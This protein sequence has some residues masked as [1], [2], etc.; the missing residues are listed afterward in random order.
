MA[1]TFWQWNIM[2]LW[3]ARRLTTLVPDRA[4]Q[5]KSKAG[6]SLGSIEDDKPAVGIFYRSQQPTCRR[7]FSHI[8]IADRWS[9]IQPLPHRKRSCRGNISLRCDSLAVS[10]QTINCPFRFKFSWIMWNYFHHLTR[11]CPMCSFSNCCYPKQ[12]FLKKSD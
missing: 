1:V 4:R 8:P 2:L 10:S 7:F 6:I 11:F 5:G 12:K 9:P 3:L